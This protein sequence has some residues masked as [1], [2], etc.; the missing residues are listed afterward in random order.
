MPL[1]ATSEGRETVLLGLVGCGIAKSRTP[2]M[3]MAEAEAHGLR[4]VYRLIDV[5]VRQP[6]APSLEAILQAA[7]LT[8]F[9]GLNITYPFKVDIL[10][11][12]DD[13]SPNAAAVGAVNTVVLRNGRRIGHNTDL[14]GFS[15]SFRRGMADTARD[16][17]LLIGAGGAGGAV[18]HALADCGVKRLSIFDADERRSA[19]L[20][21]QLGRNRPDV[22]AE[23]SPSIE[24]TFAEGLDG[25][26][27]ATPIGMVATPGSVVPAALFDPAVWFADIVYFPLETELLATARAR[28]CR[29][30][31]GSGM[32]VFQAVR[33]FELFTGRRADPN[34][35][36]ATFDAFEQQTRQQQTRQVA[37]T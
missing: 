30:L 24:E 33:A 18:A 4:A 28:G 2:E 27:N 34:R 31:P 32:A 6:N 36:T 16:H 10:P 35:M 17:V 12:L 11:L 23:A 13:V 8:G 14:W 29:V 37:E 26:V 3:H 19:A 15:E 1:R 7:E 22:I 25:I 21:E 20:A 5:D 9:D